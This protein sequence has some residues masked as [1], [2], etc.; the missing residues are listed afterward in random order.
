L[1]GPLWWEIMR[2]WVGVTEKVGPGSNK[3]ILQWARDLGAPAWYRD[4][5][6]PWCAVGSNRA[7]QAAGQPTSGQGFDLLRAA[8]FLKWGV[9]LPGPALGAIAVLRMPEGH[10]VGL[11]AGEDGDHVH[12]LGCNQSNAV[13]IARFDKRRVLGG[14]RWPHGA[15]LPATGAIKPWAGSAGEANT[16]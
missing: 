6:Q 9:E 13:G 7:L 10:H 3:V 5:D 16:R 12:L 11:Y 1:K 2:T 8:S 4:D 14:Y 15:E